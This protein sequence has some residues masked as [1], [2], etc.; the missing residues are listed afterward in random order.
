MSD[1]CFPTTVSYTLTTGDANRCCALP[2]PVQIAMTVG[3]CGGFSLLDHKTLQKILALQ[4][5]RGSWRIRISRA[6]C[7]DGL[8][9]RHSTYGT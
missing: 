4:R 3:V 6:R 8:V 7:L 1:L 2:M 9:C 5:F